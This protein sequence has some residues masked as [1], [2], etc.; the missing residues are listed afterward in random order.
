MVNESVMKIEVEL[1]KQEIDIQSYIQVLF[2]GQDLHNMSIREEIHVINNVINSIDEKINR[3]RLVRFDAFNNNEFSQF[4]KKKN[5]S[6][7]IIERKAKLSLINKVLLPITPN[8]KQ[9]WVIIDNISITQ[10]QELLYRFW[11]NYGGVWTIFFGEADFLLDSWIKVKNQKN[12][13]IYDFIIKQLRNFNNII[14][15]ND[16]YYIELLTKTKTIN[17]IKHNLQKQCTNNLEFKNI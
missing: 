7:F 8:Y 16:D 3:I 14:I 1:N 6:H 2:H 13:C 10:L 17:E 5:Y 4:L 12:Y 11:Y 9:P 15:I